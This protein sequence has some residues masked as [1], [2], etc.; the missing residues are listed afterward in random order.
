MGQTGVMKTRLDV[1]GAGVRLAAYTEGRPLDSGAPVVLLLHGYP[2]DH[3]VWDG[4]AEALAADHCVLR[5]DVRG[6]GASERPEAV[7]D[8]DL[9][10]LADDLF[11][12]LE[13]LV[14]DGRPV[15]LVGHDWGGIQLWEPV[16]DARATGRIASFTSVSGPCLDHAGLAMRGPAFRSPGKLVAQLRRS[17]YVGFFQLPGVAPALWRGKAGAGFP[18]RLAKT[19]GIDA[20]SLSDGLVEDGVHGIKLYRA[21][22]RDRLSKPRDRR[23]DVP[24]LLIAP[25]DDDY[26]TPLLADAA[27]GFAS[28]LYRRDVAGGHWIVRRHPKRI[29]RF[30]A[31]M[32]RHVD[33]E[34]SAALERRRV[35]PGHRHPRRLALVTG[36][37]S[38]IGEATALAFAEE[39]DD[40]VLVDLDLPSAEAVA[41]RCQ[42]F[43]VTAVAYQVDVSDRAAMEDLTERVCAL[44]GVPDVVVNNAGIGLAGP[45]LATDADAWERVLGV[46]LFGVIHGARLFGRAMV[47][48]GGGHLVNIASAAAFA[49]SRNMSAYAT[50]K[51]AV[52]MLGDCLRGEFA[53]HGVGVS[54]ICPGFVHTPITQRTQFVGLD[55]AAQAQER[56]RATAMY[57]KRNLTAEEVARAIVGA[58][59]HDRAVVP[60]G[61]EAHVL[62][63]VQ[64]WA[65]ALSRKIASLK[66]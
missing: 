11:A 3:T 1:V 36:A 31:E 64:R 9:A 25:A 35:R 62:D 51:A 60:V 34:P 30:V 21:N 45:F 24:T 5:Y 4:V 65:P 29:A 59:D 22:M 48:A 55:D 57:A 16:C 41:V 37:G 66:F 15:H 38:G 17:W 42:A 23:T 43:G 18:A 26:V 20:D 61:L 8:Y 27:E 52:R 12:V 58:V 7:A 44:E 63:R 39:G 19:E 13:A 33:G 2:D 53:E 54:T 56:D 28:T 47:E 14:P 49:P 46:N 10:L 40:L 50:S 6:A 32:V